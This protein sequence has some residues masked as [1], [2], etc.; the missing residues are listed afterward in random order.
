MLH[1]SAHNYMSSY[2]IGLFLGHLVTRRIV[3]SSVWGHF[4]GWSL[5][6]MACGYA[7]YITDRFERQGYTDLQALVYG[8]WVRTNGALCFL[9]LFYVCSIGRAGLIGRALGWKGF[10][11]V[12]RLSLSLFASQFLFIWFDNFTTRTPI[13][14]R[15]FALAMRVSYTLLWSLVLAYIMYLLVEA[16]ALNLT[17]WAFSRKSALKDKII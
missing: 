2:L 7:V 6:T 11:P 14:F 8:A 3:V 12:S 17:K 10:R 5:A 15:T 16:P 13:E 1:F 9:W 4:L